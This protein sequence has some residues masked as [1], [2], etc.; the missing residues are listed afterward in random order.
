V[1]NPKVAIATSRVRG[2]DNAKDVAR[3]S[4]IENFANIKIKD[5]KNLTIRIS[6]ESFKAKIKTSMFKNLV[7]SNFKP[8]LI[9]NIG[10]KK[11]YP[12]DASFSVISCLSLEE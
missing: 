2:T 3:I 1:S 6:I 8:T 12:K 7:I 10:I 11:P 5:A 9:K 4:S